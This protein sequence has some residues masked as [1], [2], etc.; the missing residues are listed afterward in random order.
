MNKH[1]LIS[2]L[3]SA[4]ELSQVH[5]GSAQFSWTGLSAVKQNGNV[6]LN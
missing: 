1:Y 3:L 5:H 6:K 2:V 4:V